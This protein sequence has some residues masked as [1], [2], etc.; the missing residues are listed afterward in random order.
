MYSSGEL[1]GSSVFVLLWKAIL[2]KVERRLNARGSRWRCPEESYHGNTRVTPQGRQKE[3]LRKQ[4]KE[5]SKQETE[6]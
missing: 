2:R 5:G 1:K 3:G 6:F 4:R